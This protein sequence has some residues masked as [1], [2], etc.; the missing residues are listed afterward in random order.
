MLKDIG[1][2]VF[3]IYIWIFYGLS[4]IS[5]ITVKDFVRI[6]RYKKMGFFNGEGEFRKELLNIILWKGIYYSY[7]LILPLIMVPLPAEV[8]MLAFFSMHF[9]TGICISIIFQTA[10]VMPDTV[11]PQ[12]N[13][14]GIIANDWAVHQLVT[15]TNYAPRRR[16]FSWLIGGLNFQIEHHLFPNVC[17]IHYQKIS[18]IV[19]ET[20]REFGMPYHVKKS[21][22]IAFCD[23][24]RMLRQLGR[25]SSRI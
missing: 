20:A 25:A 5:W 17:H 7:V 8:I 11:F 10:H 16:F 18:E 1:C 12:P 2:I 4:T 21:F 6:N 14:K 22:I 24:I 13:E 9:I 3:N 23:H 19:S 15:T